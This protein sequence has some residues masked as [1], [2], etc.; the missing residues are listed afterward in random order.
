MMRQM[1][2]LATR[3]REPEVDILDLLLFD[4]IQ[5][6]AN[7]GHGRFPSGTGSVCWIFDELDGIMPNK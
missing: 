7:V 1:M 2:P 5:N 4:Q 6:F 3:I